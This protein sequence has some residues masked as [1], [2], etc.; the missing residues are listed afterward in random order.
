MS[1]FNYLLKACLFVLSHYSALGLIAALS[2]VFGRRLTRSFAYNSFWEQLSFSIA[3][4]L[5]CIAYAVLLL[6]LLGMLFAWIVVAA[7]VIGVLLCYPIW[8]DWPRSLPNRWARLWR[9]VR[10]NRRALWL[11][12]P[13]MALLSV[14]FLI[15]PLY[16]P[17]AYDGIMYHLPYAKAYVENHG[18]V[19]T[20][21]LRFPVS[22]QT[23]EML[24]TL[25]LLLYDDILAQLIE[26]LMLLTLTLATISFGLRFF[27]PLSAVWAGAILLSNPV[28][29]WLGAS[30]YVD[31]GMTLYMMMAVYAFRCWLV[32]KERRWLILASVCCGL[33]IGVK[34]LALFIPL[35]FGIILLFHSV[36]QRKLSPLFIFGVVSL[37]IA[38]PWFVRSLYHTGNPVFPFFDE[39]FQ[40]LFGGWRRFPI[41]LSLFGSVSEQWDHVTIRRFLLLPWKLT[42]DNPISWARSAIV[43]VYFFSL[44]LMIWVAFKNNQV[45]WLLGV[46]L[47]FWVFWFCTLPDPRFIMPILPLLSIVTAVAFEGALS[48]VLPVLQKLFSGRALA[49]AGF[50]LLIPPG[51]NYAVRANPGSLPVTQEQR[52]AFLTRELPTYPAFQY[53]N[54]SRGTHYTVYTLY[55]ARMTYYADGRLIAAIFVPGRYRNVFEGDSKVGRLR[56]GQSL[57]QMMRGLGVDYFMVETNQFPVSLPQDNVFKGRF[58]LVYEQPHLQVFELVEEPSRS[59]GRTEPTGS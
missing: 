23:N 9:F 3:L 38:S 34:L 56:D 47:A 24:F 44:P 30:T 13:A 17:V 28:M 50:V 18:L 51:W 31:V 33:G 53:L 15:L 42:F 19:F 45:R 7:L 8:S 10:G 43:P 1:T 20:Q 21:Y 35:L 48:S 26:S 27:S 11:L 22:P 16:P 12:I 54:R 4:G 58:K 55:N 57:Y 49:V 39:S 14:P 29:I 37:V 6:G 59:N 36:K 32:G 25:A 52:D 2:Y 40:W 5:G 41:K 46:V